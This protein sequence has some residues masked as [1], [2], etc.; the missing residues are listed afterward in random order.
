MIGGRDGV[1]RP[2]GRERQAES[3]AAIALVFRW[4]LVPSCSPFA[5]GGIRK[6]LRVK[7]L[8]AT[9]HRDRK[10]VV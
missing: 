5:A 6:V 10:A 8:A 9:V 2:V 1:E 7:E 4:L 3:V